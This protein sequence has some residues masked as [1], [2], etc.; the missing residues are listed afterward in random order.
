MGET[1]RNKDELTRKSKNKK[2]RKKKETKAGDEED[3]KRKASLKYI[4]AEEKQ[5]QGQE[6]LATP[7]SRR[8]F[9]TGRR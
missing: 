8:C 4:M 2:H 6:G 3:L 9:H 1:A 7:G 5:P